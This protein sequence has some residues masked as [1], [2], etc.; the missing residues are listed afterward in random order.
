MVIRLQDAALQLYLKLVA[1]VVVVVNMRSPRS[2]FESIYLA[3]RAFAPSPTV[4]SVFD[5]TEPAEGSPE[6][7]VS[8]RTGTLSPWSTSLVNA[9]LIVSRKMGKQLSD[10]D[11]ASQ[12]TKVGGGHPG[13]DAIRQLRMK[14]DNDPAWH[15]GKEA[16]DAG[17]PGR[18]RVI[19]TQQENTIAASAKR[20]K[21][22]GIEPTAERVIARCKEATTNPE[23]GKP[24]CHETILNVFRSKCYD[25]DPAFPWN[26]QPPKRKT[27]LTEEQKVERCVWGQAVLDIN[28]Q[29]RWFFAHVIWMDPCNVIVPGSL[30]SIEA[31]S[32]AGR[33]RASRWM[34]DDAKD[35]SENLMASAQMGKQCRYGDKRL[36]WF[37]VLVKGKVHVEVMG[38]DWRQ[39][40]AG[41]A[42]M[43]KRLPRILSN[44][45][46]DGDAMPNVIFTDRGPGFYHS[47]TGSITPEYS[48]A[49]AE[50]GFT[51]W[52]GDHAKWQSPDIPDILLHETAV[53]WVRK[54]LRYNPVKF[55]N[56][57]VLNAERVA[58]ALKNAERHINAHH[59]V[60]DLCMAFPTRLKALVAK[61]GERCKW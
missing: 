56:D 17:T 27:A 43:V 30:Q 53:A 1:V 14:I 13:K 48:A 18:K 55:T 60:D 11:I 25:K 58:E 51:T 10:P 35:D 15:P 28:H 34:S 52:A 7:W 59:E 40:G 61:G 46:K 45:F 41:M 42:E 9:L 16:D 39:C 47:S 21:A 2:N 3:A 4:R 49:C 32:I 24:F 12:V 22:N 36:W 8:G 20:M 54:Y 50:Y 23:T 6:W 38:E 37:L 31:L 57:K 44:R 33:G 26:H 19:T 5:M 29:A